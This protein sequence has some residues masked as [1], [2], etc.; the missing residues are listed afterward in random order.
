MILG[1][2]ASGIEILLSAEEIAL[3]GGL[4]GLIGTLQERLAT[5]PPAPPRRRKN[6]FGRPA[7]AD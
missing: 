2:F 6:N 3:A 5:R 4:L 7:A 1:E